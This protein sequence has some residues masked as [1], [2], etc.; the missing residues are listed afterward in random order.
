MKLFSFMTILFLFN[1]LAYAEPRIQ[2]SDF[3]SQTSAQKFYEKLK[4]SGDKGW[5]SLDRDGDGR[6]CDCLPGGNG[7]NCPKPKI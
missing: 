5:K 2:C 4:A 6:A 3:Q 1:N 7:Q